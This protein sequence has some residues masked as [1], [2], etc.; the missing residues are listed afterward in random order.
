[1][2]NNKQI[3]NNPQQNSKERGV[4][5]YVAI[6][7]TTTLL[8]V[9]SAIANVTLKQVKLASINRD[10]HLAFFAA[11]SGAECALYWDVKAA[12]GGSAFSTTTATTI[13]C[14]ADENNPENE[15]MVVGG[16][17]TSTFRI[18]FKPEPY[19]AD[20][21]V[22]KTYNGG[23]LETHIESRGYNSCDVNNPRRVERAVQAD[24]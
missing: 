9:S 24:Y 19:C 8:L 21:T 1:M 3:T 15:N 16:D 10:S 22:V 5:L 18:L 7:I 2:R 4:T 14:N 11:D 13:S 23:V 17:E 20:V 6:I 12:G